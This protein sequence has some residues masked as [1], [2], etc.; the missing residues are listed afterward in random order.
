MILKRKKVSVKSLKILGNLKYFYVKIEVHVGLLNQVRYYDLYV[1]HLYFT[2]Q[3][4]D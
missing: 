2:Y 4:R 3:Q 1:M